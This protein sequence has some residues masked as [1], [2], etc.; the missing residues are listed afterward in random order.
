MSNNFIHEENHSGRPLLNML[1]R[2]NQ[3]WKLYVFIASMVLGAGITLFQSFLYRWLQKET[4]IALVIVGA[5]LVVGAFAWAI[6][7]ITC[8][9]CKLKL[10]KHSITNEGLGTW[11]IW[12]INLEKCP[13][14]G[15][16]DGLPAPT[17]KQGSKAKRR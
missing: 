1:K 11:F 9:N 17:N 7:S 4:I 5:L 8:P 16:T 3:L 14:C 2:T 15:S 10:F 12:L 13:Q 6:V